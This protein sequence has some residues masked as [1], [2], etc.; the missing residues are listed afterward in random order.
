MYTR[1]GVSHQYKPVGVPH[2]STPG[3]VR[4]EVRNG[5]PQT[6]AIV[7]PGSHPNPNV[8]KQGAG[9][10]PPLGT[11]YRGNTPGLT[12]RKPRVEMDPSD[13]TTWQRTYRFS[14]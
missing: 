7:R 5:I 3:F 13:S 12:P 1:D 6:W 4:M 10:Y 9:L 14:S 8:H 11:L 2:V